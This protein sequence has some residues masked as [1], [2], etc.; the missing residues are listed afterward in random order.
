MGVCFHKNGLRMS[1]QAVFC[2]KNMAMSFSTGIKP[3]LDLL[4]RY[5]SM[6]REMGLLVWLDFHAIDAQ[7]GGHGVAI[8]EG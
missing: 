8:F 6:R 3:S 7:G 1:F 2:V 5:I 4:R